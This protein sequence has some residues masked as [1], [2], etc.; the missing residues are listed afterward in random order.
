M[1]RRVSTAFAT[2]ALFVPFRLLASGGSSMPWDAPIDTLAS[3]LTG[4]VAISV[5]LIGMGFC[6]YVWMFGEHKEG[7]KTLAKVVFGG[8]CL[9][10][11]SQ[12]LGALGLTGATL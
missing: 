9:L 12:V 6:G 8:C 11:A 3:N 5:S 2:L 1:L 10:L 7:F 4:P